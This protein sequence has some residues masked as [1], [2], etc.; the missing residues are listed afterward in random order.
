[1]KV[2]HLGSDDL[3]LDDLSLIVVFNEATYSYGS[4]YVSIYRPFHKM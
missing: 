3:S 2:L 4:L 1:M